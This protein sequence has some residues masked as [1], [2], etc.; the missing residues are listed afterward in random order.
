LILT[1][2]LELQEDTSLEEDQQERLMASL[3]QAAQHYDLIEQQSR[4]LTQGKTLPHAKIVN[5]Y[6]R[7]IA[8]II[9]GKSNCPVQ[10]GCKPGIIAEMATG[11]I[12]GLHLP[13]GNPDDASYMMPLIDH[14]E[15]AIK[16]LEQKRPLCT[17]CHPGPDRLCLWV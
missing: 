2:T 9:K 5:A 17:Q 10:F 6:D 7:A 13:A 11:F 15:T 4:R 8:P 16:A 1:A 3:R 14:V 12:F